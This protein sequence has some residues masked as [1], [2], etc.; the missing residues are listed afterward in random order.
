MPNSENENLK[1]KESTKTMFLFPVIENELE[2]SLKGL[3]NRLSAGIDEIPVYIIKQCTKLLKK[4]LANIYIASL[5]SGIFPDQ[6]KLANVVPLYEKWDTRDTQNYRP[7]AL[8]SVCSKLLE[9]LVYNRLMKF[10]EKNVLLAEAQHDFR[11]KK[12]TET[13]LQIFI[14]LYPANVENMVSS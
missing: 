6:L 4:P 7:I 2:K 1:T 3:K 12:S 8:L 5:E 9:K 13:T 11:T 10:M 14:N